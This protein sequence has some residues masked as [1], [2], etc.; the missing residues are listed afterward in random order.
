MTLSTSRYFFF[1]VWLFSLVLFFPTTLVTSSNFPVGW[2]LS[3]RVGGR[4]GREEEMELWL[5]DKIV[6]LKNEKL[7][8]NI[9]DVKLRVAIREVQKKFTSCLFWLE[10]IPWLLGK[11][12]KF[13]I[14]FAIICKYFSPSY[15]T[16]FFPRV[17][18]VVVIS[19]LRDNGGKIPYQPISIY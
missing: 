13:I 4:I 9:G 1:I 8:R 18:V 19:S 10:W 15:N 14:H 12:C 5:T 6:S 17:T 16:T 11:N 7:V 2:R 3:V